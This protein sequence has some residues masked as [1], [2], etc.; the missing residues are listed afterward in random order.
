MGAYFSNV[1][2]VINHLFFL[3][4]RAFRLSLWN[5]SLIGEFDSFSV[6]AFR[7]HLPFCAARERAS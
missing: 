2:G 5:L 1:P 4:S 3:H 7:Q 6:T